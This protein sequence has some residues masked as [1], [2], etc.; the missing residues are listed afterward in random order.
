MAASSNP[1]PAAFPWRRVFSIG[2]LLVALFVLFLALKKP[3][4]VSAPQPPAAVAA[5]ATSFQQKVDQ[6][7]QNKEPEDTGAEIPE[8]RV[9]SNEIAA[10]IA[11]ANGLTDLSTTAAAAEDAPVGQPVVTMEGDVVK[12][13]FESE[14]GGK[15]VYVTVAGHL[16]ARDGYATFEPTEF[17]I[18]DLEVPVSLVNGALQK[19]LAEQKDRLK[20]PDYIGDLKVENGELV[21]KPK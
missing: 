17:K 12:G 2:T 5:N 10:A 4:H 1:K 16:G 18:G 11:Q 7:A 15:K 13:Q 19:R 21:I 14:I 3:A 9:T 6:L 8:V 20:L